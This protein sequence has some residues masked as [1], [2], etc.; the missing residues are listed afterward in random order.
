MSPFVTCG[1]GIR[2]GNIHIGE[3]GLGVARAAA[4]DRTLAGANALAPLPA[5]AKGAGVGYLIIDEYQVSLLGLF[6]IEAGQ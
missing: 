2:V 3:L 5:E 6:G 4:A 1:G